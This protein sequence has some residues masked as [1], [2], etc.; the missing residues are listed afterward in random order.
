M[1]NPT[2]SKRKASLA[3][4]NASV[5]ALLQQPSSLASTML[6]WLPDSA[7]NTSKDAKSLLKSFDL[8]RA[9]LQ[10]RTNLLCLSSVQTGAES[11]IL[12][13]GVAVP[14]DV[15]LQVLGFLP[16]Y[17]SVQNAS[18]VS[19]AW[20]AGA[21]SPQ[22]WHTL[23]NDYG[24]LGH[25]TTIVNM[26]SLLELLDRP[27]FT[28]LKTLIPPSNIQI[29]K[30]A[31]G[32]IAEACPIL[33]EIDFGY[34]FLSRLKPD[35]TDLN[36]LPALFPHLTKIR[37]NQDKVTDAGITGFCECMGDRLMSIQIRDSYRCS[38]KLSDDTLLTMSRCCPNLERFD[39]EYRTIS[40]EP[41]SISEKGVI[42]LV[43]GCPNL[44]ILNLI[45]MDSIGSAAFEY[46][47]EN[48]N[49]N[50]LLVRGDNI[51][52]TLDG[53]KALGASL[54]EKVGSFKAFSREMH[55]AHIQ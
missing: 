29:R 42:A 24:L 11:D 19:K 34:S 2:S 28:S 25:S 17:E 4:T 43:K 14:P 50:R 8:V 51:E 6:G 40:A 38:Q 30:K 52:L 27:Q 49:L 13:Q 53:N 16:R 54:A 10:H 55:N 5:S 1:S 15:L 23:D 31:I 41:L 44:K 39:Y 47:L 26:T 20:L 12:L 9:E 46:I 21:R 37:L 35:D 32:K 48:G 3:L 36:S 7:T 22:L 18:L 33:E 45:G